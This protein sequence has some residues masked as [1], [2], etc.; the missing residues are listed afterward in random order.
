[1]LFSYQK[2]PFPLGSKYR[3]LQE[4]FTVLDSLAKQADLAPIGSVLFDMPMPFSN[5]GITHPIFT[6]SAD[7]GRAVEDMRENVEQ[8]YNYLNVYC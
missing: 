7:F 6:R 2:K 3:E 1:V 8:I 4:H 5:I